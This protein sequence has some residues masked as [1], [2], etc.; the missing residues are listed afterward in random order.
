[1]RC[2]CSKRTRSDRQYCLSLSRFQ[3]CGQPEPETNASAPSWR[4]G[5]VVVHAA[6]RIPVIAP[7][8]IGRGFHPSC[9]DLNEAL[10]S[11]ATLGS[12]LTPVLTKPF[13]SKRSSV[14][15]RAPIEQKHPVAFSILLRIEASPLVDESDHTSN[16]WH[17]PEAPAALPNSS[18]LRLRN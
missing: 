17:S 18:I 2:R 9:R 5:T 12:G 11:S 16:P 10:G 4:G 14:V 13:P 7:E 6:S 15:Y 3:T 8:K 1:M